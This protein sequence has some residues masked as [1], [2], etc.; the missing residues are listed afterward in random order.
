MSELGVVAIGRNEG[1]RLRRCLTSLSGQGLTIVY[2]DSGSE[3][4]SV[5]LAQSMGADVVELDMSRPFTAARARNQ[6][7]ERLCELDPRVRFVQFIDGDCELAEGWL[8][9]AQRALEDHP[10]AAVVSGRL[11]ERHPDASVYNR[12]ADLEWDTPI[13]E[14]R[15]CGGIAMIRLGAFDEA[16]C[17][18]PAVIAGE[19]PELCLRLRR[20]GWTILRIDAEMALHDMGMTRFR[21]WWNRAVRAGHAY[22]EGFAMHGRGPDRHFYRETRSILIWGILMPV[23]ALGLAWPTRGLSLALLAGY[24]LLYRKITRYYTEQRFWPSPLARLNATWIVLAKFPEAVGLIR[25]GIGAL[26]GKRSAVIEHRP[27]EPAGEAETEARGPLA[28][29]TSQDR[30]GALPRR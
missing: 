8:E 16:G 29:V 30:S 5:E 9:K 10:R 28:R 6:G 27:V 21:Q 13:G 15:A 11:R 17:F 25:Y 18:D 12:L 20:N 4:G 22:A 14:A 23:L 1:E 19:E 2:V 3:D 7:A 26:T 24:F